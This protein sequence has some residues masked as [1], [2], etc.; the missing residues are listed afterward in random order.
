MKDR[1]TPQ[2]QGGCGSSLRGVK[3]RVPR[4]SN[5]PSWRLLRSARNDSI[6]PLV[7]EGIQDRNEGYRLL[8]KPMSDIEK[9]YDL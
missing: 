4:E 6:L 7:T 2:L 9:H 8:L 1:V 3:S 5:P